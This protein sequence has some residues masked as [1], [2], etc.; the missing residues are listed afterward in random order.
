MRIFR[1]IVLAASLLFLAGA[2]LSAQNTRSQETRK[3]KLE[4]EIE[5]L[6]R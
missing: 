2:G 3:A 6:N 5:L 1:H 4:K